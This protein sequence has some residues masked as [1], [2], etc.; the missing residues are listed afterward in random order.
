MGSSRASIGLL[1]TPSLVGK[2]I[3]FMS[4]AEEFNE[5]CAFVKTWDNGKSANDEEKLRAYKWYKQATVGDTD[6]R[7][8]G[9][10]EITARRK[11]DAWNSVKGKN[12]EEAMREYVIEI[13]AQRS[14][15]GD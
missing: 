8:P 10:L 9:I 3:V 12:K 2:P 13:K 11:W 7:R 14:K 5:C 15:Y 1:P 4:N 6:T